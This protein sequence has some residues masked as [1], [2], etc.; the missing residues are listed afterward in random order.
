MSY[1][2]YNY[3]DPLLQYLPLYHVNSSFYKFIYTEKTHI[4]EHT[5]AL[6]TCNKFFISIFLKINM[7]IRYRAYNL[8]NLTQAL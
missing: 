6:S 1:Y 3:S 5:P 8:Y 2:N 7:A 4:L